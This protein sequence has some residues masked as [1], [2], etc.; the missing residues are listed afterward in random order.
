LLDAAG[1]VRYDFRGDRLQDLAAA[2]AHRWAVQPPRSAVVTDADD[3]ATLDD[4]PG[5]A[6]DGRAGP[7]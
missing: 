7:A 2:V 1:Y 3:L 5:G 6:G 4:L